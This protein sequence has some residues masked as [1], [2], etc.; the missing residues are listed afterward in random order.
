MG[1]AMMRMK[2]MMMEMQGTCS[3]CH[4]LTQVLTPHA[5]KRFQ[6]RSPSSM[7]YHS[8]QP[9]RRRAV[10]GEEVDLAPL[11]ILLHR[12]ADLLPCGR[13]IM[14]HSSEFRFGAEKKITVVVLQV[15][16]LNT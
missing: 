16:I 4:S 12:R 6:L 1:A 9:L 10:V 7:L 8:S 2:R 15:T 13:N 5:W 11:R 3:E 14:L